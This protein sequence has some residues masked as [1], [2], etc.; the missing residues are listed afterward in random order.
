MVCVQ[1]LT[2]Q[3]ITRFSLADP[4]PIGQFITGMYNVSPNNV[5]EK[6]T[7]SVQN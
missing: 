3:T 1:N 7:I 4:H 2:L 6:C 5:Y